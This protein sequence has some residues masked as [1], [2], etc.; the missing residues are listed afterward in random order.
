MQGTYK[1]APSLKLGL[2]YGIS[3]NSEN[4]VGTGGLKSNANLTL[5]LYYALT[6]AITL[7]GEAG[8]TRSK[9]F[10][11]GE[12]RMHGGSLGGIIFF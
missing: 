4:T 2:G 11:G 8:Q 7:V 6:P 12:A 10:D 3:R 5:G 9:G 1:P